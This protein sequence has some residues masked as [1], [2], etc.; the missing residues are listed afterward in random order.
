MWAF[1]SGRTR[2]AWPEARLAHFVPESG[3]NIPQ[4]FWDYLNASGTIY[5]GRRYGSGT[6][7]NW[8]F[9]LGYPISEPYWTRI[10]VG[11]ADRDVLVQPFQRRVLT[12]SPDNPSGWQVEMGNVG[13]HY[14]LWR[15]GEDLP[16]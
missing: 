15:Y 1:P 11:G 12:Y 9:T 14:Y 4:V 13:R 2:A 8:V 10:K 16:S 6:L 5:E 7:V 3:H